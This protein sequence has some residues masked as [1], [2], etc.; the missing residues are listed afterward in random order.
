LTIFFN[1]FVQLAPT[2]LLDVKSASIADDDSR[3]VVQGSARYLIKAKLQVDALPPFQ[4]GVFVDLPER[5]MA[6]TN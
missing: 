5:C 4:M 2:E 1:L 6:E 3:R